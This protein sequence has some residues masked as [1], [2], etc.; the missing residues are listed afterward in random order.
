MQSEKLQKIDQQIISD[1]HYATIEEAALDMLYLSAKSR[2]SEYD[3]EIFQ[4]EKKYGMSFVDFIKVVNNKKNE[5]SFEEDDDLMA[6]QF[7]YENS[8]YWR[9]KVQELENCLLT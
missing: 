2:L 1:L 7:A 4:Y 9:K 8:S 3:E 6:W 5:E